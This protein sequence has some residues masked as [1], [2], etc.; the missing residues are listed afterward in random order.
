MNVA[1]RFSAPREPVFRYLADPRHRPAW[2]SSLRAVE[3]IDDGEPRVG[4]RWRDVTRPG[5]VPELW[6][7]ALEPGRLWA[8]R[9][10]WRGITAEL[11]L[12]FATDG[13]GT[14]VEA[15]ATLAGAGAWR[16]VAT[17]AGWLTP[18]AVRRDLERA[19]A[20]LERG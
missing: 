11:A 14:I 12:R 16:P 20:I 2:Q 17:A 1:V 4:L 5:L 3:M 6:I 9:G 10:R 8:E 18:W 15:D 7:S 13:T 19:A